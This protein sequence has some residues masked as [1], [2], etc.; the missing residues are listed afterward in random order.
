MFGYIDA[1]SDNS[2]INENSKFKIVWNN[3]I[4]WVTNYIKI[5][6]Y[7]KDQIT[8]KVKDNILKIAGQNMSIVMLQKKEMIIK[9]EFASISLDKKNIAE[10]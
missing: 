8:L 4:I 5:L 3:D 10:K 2:I 6:Y 1:I 7:E 9:G